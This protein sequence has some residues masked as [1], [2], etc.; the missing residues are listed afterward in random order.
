[1]VINTLHLSNTERCLQN[2]MYAPL[3]TNRQQRGDGSLVIY[4]DL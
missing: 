4:R 1:M 2:G 3:T